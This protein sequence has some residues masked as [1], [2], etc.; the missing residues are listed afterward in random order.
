M[1]KFV[2]SILLILSGL[3]VGCE[4]DG[5]KNIVASPGGG[6]LD[7]S[8]SHIEVV[9]DTSW[10]YFDGEL[11]PFER[12][13]YY[14]ARLDFDRDRFTARFY[15]DSISDVRLFRT[16]SGPV[17]VSADSLTAWLTDST[18]TE[19]VRE[20]DLL[21]HVSGDTLR[22]RFLTEWRLSGDSIIVSDS[23]GLF[24]IGFPP[25]DPFEDEIDLATFIR[26]EN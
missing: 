11:I 9:I 5:K 21:Y 19:V 18:G 16:L 2:L 23:T 22:L 14:A 6:S 10:I 26:M 13:S 7:G 25:S 8:W 15:F 12:Q 20:N 4:V 17:S 24:W 3:F 1:R